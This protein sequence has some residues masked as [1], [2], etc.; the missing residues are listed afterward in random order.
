VVADSGHPARTSAGPPGSDPAE[1]RLSPTLAHG[2]HPRIDGV[3]TLEV[4]RWR[5]KCAQT[6]TT[7]WPGYA[8]LRSAG[9]CAG[10][11]FLSD[12]PELGLVQFNAR[13]RL[14]DTTP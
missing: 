8:L 1:E 6:P 5:R 2:E 7:W 13:D 10:T 3:Q 14:L 12:R 4:S 9:Q 11:D